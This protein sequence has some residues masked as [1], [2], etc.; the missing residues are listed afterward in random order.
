MASPIWSI[1][2]AL[3]A[4]LLYGLTW[5]NRLIRDPVTG[6]LKALWLTAEANALID[7]LHL[8]DGRLPEL[9]RWQGPVPRLGVLVVRIDPPPG[10]A[11]A[12]RYSLHLNRSTG[13]YWI[14][15]RGGLLGTRIVYGP[16]LLK[17]GDPQDAPAR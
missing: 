5:R 13:Q 15:R 3:T 6:R 4:T 9:P 12:A 14:K 16:G 7:G 1:L 11:D 2:A 17:M 10:I 8:R